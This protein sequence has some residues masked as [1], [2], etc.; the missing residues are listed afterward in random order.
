MTRQSALF[1]LNVFKRDELNFAFFLARALG[2]KARKH[3]E[4]ST[5]AALTTQ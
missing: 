2:T 1:L 5:A 4:V 3:V